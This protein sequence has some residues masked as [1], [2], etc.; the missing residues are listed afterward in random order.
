MS[1]DLKLLQRHV[2]MLRAVSENEPIGIIKLATQL[3]LPQHKVRY[4]LRLLEKDG[5]IDATQTGAR[6]TN[7]TQKF[8]R[9]LKKDMDI[10]NKTIKELQK[11]L[12]EVQ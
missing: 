8:L 10:L 5:I 1:D 4:S 7:K 2:L 3:K 11:S 6:T 9:D 12:K